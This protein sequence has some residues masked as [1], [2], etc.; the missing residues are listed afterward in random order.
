[1]A[2]RGRKPRYISA[3]Q[4]EGLIDA[5]FEECKGEVLK[6]KD[7]EIMLNKHGE[8]IVL[9]AMPPTVTGL[10]LALGFTS[11]QNMLEYQ[12]KKEFTDTITRAKSFCEK[13]AE[14]RLFDRDGARGA[15]FSLKCN[16]RWRETADDQAIGESSNIIEAIE[17]KA[18]I[19]FTDDADLV[20]EDET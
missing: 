6:D 7:G 17:G 3:S 4:I 14:S 20:D 11:R 18:P 10:A 15:E 13:Y 8:P 19:L 2:T 1:M 16:F 5:Y 9:N 12:G